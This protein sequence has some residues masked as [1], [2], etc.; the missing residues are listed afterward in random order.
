MLVAISNL[1]RLN[2]NLT[3]SV[4]NNFARK[5]GKGKDDD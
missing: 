3:K 5:K 1:K 4:I 2:I